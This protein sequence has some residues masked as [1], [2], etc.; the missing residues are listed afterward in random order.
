MSTNSQMIAEGFIKI[1]ADS[2]D[3]KDRERATSALASIIRSSFGAGISEGE[4]KFDQKIYNA[5]QN[6]SQLSEEEIFNLLSKL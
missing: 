2:I 4:K 3:E 5:L 6:K 1:Y